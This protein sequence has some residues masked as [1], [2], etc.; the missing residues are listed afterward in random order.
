M[1][2]GRRIRCRPRGARFSSCRDPEQQQCGLSRRGGEGQ[3]EAVAARA[4]Q[5]VQ[6]EAS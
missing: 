6:V 2:N 4:G 5:R 1:A 3:T